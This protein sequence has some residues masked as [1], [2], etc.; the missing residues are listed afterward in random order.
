MANQKRSVCKLCRREG[1]KLFLKGQRCFSEKCGI[2]R[3]DYPPGM[4]TRP[5]KTTDYCVQLREKQKA[6]RTFGVY[7]KPFRLMF[8]AA[9]RMRGNTGE[10]MIQLLERRLDN[11]IYLAGFAF[12]RAHGNLD[13]QV[14]VFFAMVVA[15]AEVAVG[16]AIVIALFRLRQSTDIDDAAE[17]GDVDY[18]P[19][20]PLKLEGEDHHHDHDDHDDHASDED[21]DPGET[22]PVV[23]AGEAGE[24]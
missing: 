18:G 4:H 24:D 21:D 10:N 23:A 5:R 13:G 7:E 2:N 3:R 17:L 11:V 22:E 15:A 19:I 6:K 1:M 16:L 14:F 8:A 12:S 9:S 20:P